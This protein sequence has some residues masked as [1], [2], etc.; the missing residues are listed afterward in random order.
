MFPRFVAQCSIAQQQQRYEDVLLQ[1][2]AS[3]GDGSSR[4]F[5]CW[6]LFDGHRGDTV[7]RFLGS[8]LLPDLEKRLP[9]VPS[10]SEEPEQYVYADAVRRAVTAAFLSLSMRVR[11]LTSSTAAG[12]GSAAAVV[13][14][15]GH[16]LTVANAGSSKCI[17]D[18]G[19]CA[20]ECSADHRLGY[21][22]DEE[23]RL[24][25]GGCTALVHSPQWGACCWIIVQVNV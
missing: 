16:L 7:A 12:C 11:E 13:V 2:P 22:E 25:A 18:V 19:Q 4:S 24:D 14:Q 23:Q 5:S 10:P 20:I 1:A 3:A 9:A 17:L 8:S 6:A 21:N 15:T